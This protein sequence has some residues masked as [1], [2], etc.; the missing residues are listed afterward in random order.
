MPV[1]PEIPSLACTPQV[2]VAVMERE[3]FYLDF[4]HSSSR[5]GRGETKQNT[6]VTVT[7]L[8]QGIAEGSSSLLCTYHFPRGS[9]QVLQNTLHSKLTP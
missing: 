7:R 8:S 6:A 9:S 3:H 1:I 5:S 4:V 2:T